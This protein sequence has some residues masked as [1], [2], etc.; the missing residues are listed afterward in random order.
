[1]I[2][3]LEQY[4]PVGSDLT[5]MNTYYNY[6]TFKDGKKIADDFIV[7]VYKD[8]KSGEKNYKIIEK[9]TYTYYLLKDKKDH[10]DYNRLFIEKDR[11][12]EVRVPFVDLEKSIAQNTGNEEFYK[13]NLYNGAKKENKKLH[14][15]PDVFFS[16]SNIE[17][18]YRFKF[19]NT[20]TNNI[21]KLRKGFFDI[22]VDGK[23][24]ANDIP[25]LGECP[26]NAVT[27][28]DDAENKA[29]TFLLRD[30]NNPLIEKFENMIKQKQFTNASIREFIKNHVG[31]SIA[32]KYKLLDIAWEIN[33]YDHDKEILLIKDLFAT[34]HR[35]SPDF[36]EG[37]NSS[38]F[39]IQYLIERICNL[40]YDPADIMCDQNWKVKVVKNKIDFTHLNEFA[41][42]G[43]YTFI[44]GLPVFIDQMIQYVS[45]RK[46]KVG[47]YKSFKLD[48]I[49]L[50]EAGVRKA[51]Y[52]H[53]TNNLAE[54][55]YL[56]YTLFVLYNM[57]DVMAQ[58]C[59]E[60]QTEDLEYIF[61]KCVI[62]NTSY[63][64]GHRQTVYLINRMANEWYKKGYIIGNNVNKWND[65]PPKFLGALVGDP[66]KTNDYAKLKIDGRPIWICDN[67]IDFDFTSLY[68][69]IMIEF[70][71]APNTQIG[72]III[73][74]KVYSG[75]NT[76]KIDEEKYSRS[77]EFIENLVTD[78]IIEFCRRWFNLAGINELL[79][80]IAE[81]FNIKANMGSIY[82][83]LYGNTPIS[84]GNNIEVAISFS[85]Q[86][87]DKPVYFYNN[88]IQKDYN[89]I[90]G[91][92]E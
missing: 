42:R 30:D 34:M 8:N 73:P 87:V 5:I 38:A 68:P 70:N 78:N 22:E 1:M 83:S 91:E 29:Y 63:N 67:C 89:T 10:V 90:K 55:P 79:E 56:D 31:E 6:P 62:N 57:M 61:A 37:W 21:E 23:Y 35:T 46:S 43:D 44:S 85:N 84:I 4:Y 72:R 7:L 18:H 47:S 82:S 77:G 17:D 53:I 76:Y 64:K 2:P 12:E 25:E 71:I 32:N 75:E 66:L 49:A 33:F 26:V 69:S 40:G 24:S 16:D 39:D 28:L 65:K 11:V 15:D 36:I 51:V 45:R 3:E 80:D 50:L 52:S 92:N 19:N 86:V 14:T 60:R 74:N 88:R 59:I 20:Y 13:Y 81:Y 48:D 27:Y 58:R 9:P 41:E 54:L